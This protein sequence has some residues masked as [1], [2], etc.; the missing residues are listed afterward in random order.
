MEDLPLDRIAALVSEFAVKDLPLGRT[1]MMMMIA[2]MI[3]V[4]REFVYKLGFE[5]QISRITF[6]RS[7]VEF[8]SW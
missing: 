4:V 8:V 6:Q 1:L 2:Y 7:T 3:N 5:P